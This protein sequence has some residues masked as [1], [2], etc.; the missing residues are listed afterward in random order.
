MYYFI[1]TTIKVAR[2]HL[3]VTLVPILPDLL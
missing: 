2:T 3:N 1:S